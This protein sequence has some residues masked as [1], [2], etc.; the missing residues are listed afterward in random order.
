MSHSDQPKLPPHVTRDDLV[1]RKA[2]VFKSYHACVRHDR[3]LYLAIVGRQL[4]L[5]NPEE[6]AKGWKVRTLP[7]GPESADLGYHRTQKLA[8]DAVFEHYD[9]LRGESP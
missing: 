3:T 2:G 6:H 8:L 7:F 9:K 5:V 4:K 1:L